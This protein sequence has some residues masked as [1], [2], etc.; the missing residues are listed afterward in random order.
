MPA[1]SCNYGIIDSIKSQ[2]MGVNIKKIIAKLPSSPGV[3]LF[4]GKNKKILY[5]GKAT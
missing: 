3:Y 5:I 1:P 4:L 2:L